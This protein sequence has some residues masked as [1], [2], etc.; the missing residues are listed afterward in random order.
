MKRT[1]T[2]LLAVAAA[3]AG[4]VAVRAHRQPSIAA[5]NPAD[6]SAD[7]IVARAQVRIAQNPNDP[8]SHAL[9]AVGA[10]AMVKQTADSSWYVRADTAVTRALALDP[11]HVVALETRATLAN[12]RHRFRDALV[13]AQRARTLAPDRFAALEIL[14]DAN[15]E[16]GNYDA[17]FH[18]ADTR[19]ALRPDLASYSRASYA[20]ELRGDRALATQLMARAAD[21]ARVGSADRAWAL[22]HVGLLRLG[23]G[24]RA[25]ARR[26]LTVAQ[27]ESPGDATV[28]AGLA[29]I[30]AAD[31]R[32]AEA[33]ALYR[34][35]LD[36]QQTA[37]VAAD[38]AAVE[39]AR[40]RPTASAHAL[41]LARTLDRREAAN[42]VALDLDALAVEADYRRPSADEVRRA[43]EGH[44]NRTGV[45]GDDSLGWVLTR[46]GN[47]REGLRFARRSL[48]IGT[49]DAT[50]LFH[51]AMAARCAGR[52]DEA[53]GYLRRA[54]DLNPAFSPRWSHTAKLMLRELD[55][56]ARP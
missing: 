56:A 29:R 18:S 44:R 54:L 11:D 24:D 37:P 9:F 30:T 19:L 45:V 5:A 21:S 15:I 47:C 12:A 31:G 53:R 50:M 49:Q 43:R 16:L 36:A 7:A 40:G 41:D 39:F 34:R 26:E 51:A 25:G 17:A 23:S 27:A 4:V 42:G 38:L 13:P 33:A 20:A 55:G 22:V 14:T 32:L 35:A 10:L 6:R 2:L 52:R 28:L 48:R 8:D 46:S 3:T 1:I